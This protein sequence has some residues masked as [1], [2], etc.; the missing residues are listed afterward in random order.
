MKSTLQLHFVRAGLDFRLIGLRSGLAV[1]QVHGDCRPR[2]EYLQI[3]PVAK[4]GKR[5]A[6]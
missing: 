3:Q 6:R 2:L 1:Y 5:G 4:P